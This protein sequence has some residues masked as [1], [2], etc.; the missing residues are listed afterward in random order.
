MD[1]PVDGWILIP[2]IYPKLCAEIRDECMDWLIDWF[3]LSLT[4]KYKINAKPKRR[5]ANDKSKNAK[6]DSNSKKLTKK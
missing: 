3:Y 2:I 1:R 5:D 6:P 4:K